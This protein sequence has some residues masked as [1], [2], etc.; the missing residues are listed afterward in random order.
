M[1]DF[2]CSLHPMDLRLLKIFVAAVLGD[3]IPDL[4]EEARRRRQRDI[5]INWSRKI[6]RAATRLSNQV[7]PEDWTLFATLRPLFVTVA[8]AEEAARLT[9]RF[10]SAH[11]LEEVLNLFREEVARIDPDQADAV[12][13]A[14]HEDKTPGLL[15][16][17][18]VDEIEG[19]LR[20]YLLYERRQLQQLA[21]AQLHPVE[22]V[23]AAGRRLAW[24]SCTFLANIHPAWNLQGVTLTHLTKRPDL[25]LEP[26]VADPRGMYAEIARKVPGLH[27][28]IPYALS[29]AQQTGLCVP[30]KAVPQVLELMDVWPSPVPVLGAFVV[31]SCA[32]V[33]ALHEALH[34]AQLHHAG[35]WEATDLL[36]PE[37]D[38]IPCIRDDQGD[39]EEHPE[40]YHHVGQDASPAAEVPWPGSLLETQQEYVRRLQATAP[41]G[42]TIP[43]MPEVG[44]SAPK[45]PWWKRLF[46][47]ARR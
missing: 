42:A 4:N 45:L 47:G 29:G 38:I 23:A 30:P 32:Q 27:D 1:A 33:R 25:R 41:V 26:L 5:L 40:K 31:P 24:R 43:E 34:Y 46:S 35:L 14:A 6:T 16:A 39:R 21:E 15:S 9:D 22:E 10:F 8:D 44:E 7:L 12:I 18:P 28:H 37:R 17:H 13:D 2:A 3:A 20:A 11:S 19:F 36:V